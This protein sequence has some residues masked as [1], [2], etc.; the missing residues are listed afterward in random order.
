M[1]RAD[2]HGAAFA[3]GRESFPDPFSLITQVTGLR[4]VPSPDS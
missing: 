3:T 2:D 1:G 4:G